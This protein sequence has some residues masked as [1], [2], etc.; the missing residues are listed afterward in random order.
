MLRASYDDQG[1][2]TRT[3]DQLVIWINEVMAR[4]ALVTDF[5]FENIDTGSLANPLVV[6]TE[7]VNR[8]RA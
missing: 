4:A 7:T 1:N 6:S 8:S 3:D 2:P 5:V